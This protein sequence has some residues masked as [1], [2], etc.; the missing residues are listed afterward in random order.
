MTVPINIIF[1]KLRRDVKLKCHCICFGS[2]RIDFI[3][4]GILLKNNPKHLYF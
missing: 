4:G 1:K 3:Y 2:Q